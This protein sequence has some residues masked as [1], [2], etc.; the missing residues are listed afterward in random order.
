MKTLLAALLLTTSFGSIAQAEDIRSI[1]ERQSNV[2]Q[3][4]PPSTVPYNYTVDV[5]MSGREGKEQAG[6]FTAKLLVDPSAAPEGRVTIL[7]TS[8]DEYGEEFEAFLKDMQNPDMSAQDLADEFWCESGKNELFE[9]DDLSVDD[10]TVVS[11]TSTEAVIKP[12]LAFMAEIMMDSDED[13]DMSKSQRKMMNKMME[14]LDGEFVLSK[15]DGR[16]R[17]MKVWLTRP[18]TMKVVAKLKEMEVTK[19][20]AMAPNGFTY[21]DSMTMRVKAKALGMAVEQN[22]D[23]KISGLTLR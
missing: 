23:I 17:R 3:A 13:E 14:R 22:M 10:F 18:L 7:S 16:L 15:P 2:E 4:A 9:G 12:N 19:S 20:C 8:S 5:V 21:T 6:P 11:E 1:L